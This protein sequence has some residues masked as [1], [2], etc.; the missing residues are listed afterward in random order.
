M[1]L[2]THYV[3]LILDWLP[4]SGL[5]K[6]QKPPCRKNII[7]SKIKKLTHFLAISPP[8]LVTSNLRHCST[9][10]SLSTFRLY[11]N[12]SGCWK[13][14]PCFSEIATSFCFA[15]SI[16][17]VLILSLHYPNFD[18]PSSPFPGLITR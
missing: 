15:C 12:T 18:L 13:L 17:G 3:R 16:F 11:A 2:R 4:S 8:P 5:V 10:I 7:P 14:N 9:L 1:I 6:C